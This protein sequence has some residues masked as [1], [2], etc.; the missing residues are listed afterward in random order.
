MSAQEATLAPDSGLGVLEPGQIARSAPV[1]FFETIYRE[2]GGDLSRIPW[3]DGKPN[4]SLV[5]WLNA[6]AAGRIRPGARAVVVGC[7]L[8]DDVVELINRGYD[9][10]GFDLSPTAIVWARRRFPEFANAF[11]AS[12][13]LDM[14][15]RCRHRFDV[16][17]EAYTLQSV[18]PAMRESMAAA[19]ASL[20]CPRG[21]IVTIA[22]GRDESEPLESIQGP[23]FPFTPAELIGLFEA[24]GW[25]PTRPLDD[26]LDDE[27]PPKRRLRGMFI[28]G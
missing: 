28:H 14:P 27:A 6:E 7:G 26:F 13:L 12:N 24:Q 5:S 25:Q 3:A 15:S 10:S 19:V 17:V 18:E 21:L 9:A 11:F 2:A 20:A 8:G 1:D 16:V 23:P 22:R 4:P